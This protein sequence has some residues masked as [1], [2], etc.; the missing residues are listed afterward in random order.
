MLQTP[1]GPNSHIAFARQFHVELLR[2]GMNRLLLR[3]LPT[4][5]DP[6]RVEVYFPYVQHLDIPMRFEEL[7]IYNAVGDST[8]REDVRDILRKFSD[9]QL[10]KLHSR[11]ALVGHIVAAH[12]VYGEDDGPSGSESMFPIEP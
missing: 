11:A 12:C 2:G 3:A 5:L 7:T 1:L 4:K 9:C 6:T 10:F 8:L